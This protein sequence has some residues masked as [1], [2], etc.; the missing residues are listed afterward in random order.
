MAGITLKTSGV[1]R[2]TEMLSPVLYVMES[3]M[4]NV[5]INVFYTNMILC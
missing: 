2:K 1:M 4:L 5:A 3:I